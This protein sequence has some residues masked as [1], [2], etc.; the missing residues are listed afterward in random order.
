MYGPC[1]RLGFC[2]G[3]YQGN[4][5]LAKLFIG[6]NSWLCQ[7]P[8]LSP[9]TSAVSVTVR[10]E[11]FLAEERVAV[12]F[13]GI[14]HGMF[15]HLLSSSHRQ[16]FVEE[17][18]KS[19]PW[20]FYDLDLNRSQLLEIAKKYAENKSSLGKKIETRRSDEVFQGRIFFPRLTNPFPG[21]PSLASWK[22]TLDPGKGRHRMHS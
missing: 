2:Q 10:F 8:P 9:F 21:V 1:C 18:F 11:I 19:K 13:Q 17:L 7:I 12:L 3:K 14:S 6:R 16:R 15:S 22:G 4:C 20:P 5:W